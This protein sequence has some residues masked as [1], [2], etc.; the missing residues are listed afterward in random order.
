MIIDDVLMMDTWIRQLIRDN[1]GPNHVLRHNGVDT[2]LVASAPTLDSL[3]RVAGDL[4]KMGP[5]SIHLQQAVFRYRQMIQLLLGSH[6]PRNPMQ[7]DFQLTQ[8][9]FQAMLTTIHNDIELYLPMMFRAMWG[10]DADPSQLMQG[11]SIR[12]ES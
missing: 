6:D 4:H 2:P 1:R 8:M 7:A 11:R 3:T 10:A 12:Q 9:G 5:G